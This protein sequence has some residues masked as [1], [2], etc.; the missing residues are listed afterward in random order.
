[1]INTMVIMMLKYF[2]ERIL[3]FYH[4]QFMIRLCSQ[5]CQCAVMMSVRMINTNKSTVPIVIMM[6]K[7]LYFL[8][9]TENFYVYDKALQPWLM[10]Q[11][12]K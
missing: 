6:L 11:N 9:P 5:H 2:G 7:I 3:Y 10:M 4:R 8:S 12:E 1:M